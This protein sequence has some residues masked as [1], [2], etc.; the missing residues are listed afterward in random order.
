MKTDLWQLTARELTDGYRAGTFT[1]LEALT[2]IEGRLDAVNAKINAVVARD[3]GAARVQA[4]AATSRWR[5]GKPLSPIDGVP[6]TIKDNLLSAGLPAT[7][8][9][10]LYSGH[11]PAQDEAPVVRL[12]AAGAVFLGKTN[13]PEFTLQ[14]Y[15]TNLTFGTTENPHAPGMTPGGSTGGGAAAVA[16]GIGPVA[17]GTDGGGSLR[18]PAAHCGLYALK[19]SIGQIARYNGF[20]Q[21]L[22][23]FEVVGPVARNMEDLSAVFSVLKGY[24]TADPSSLWALAPPQPLP[25]RARIAYLPKIGSAPIDPLI[26]EAADAFAMQ[27][28]EAGHSIETIKTPYDVDSVSAAWSTIAASGLHWHLDSIGRR[29]GLGANALALDAQGGARTAAD[30]ADAMAV[31]LAARADAGRLLSRYDLLL[32]PSTAALAWPADT[33]YPAEIDGKPVGPRGHAVF[34]GWMNVTGVCA[35]NIPVAM[36][37]DHG[38]IG[39]QLVAAVGRDAELIDFVSNLPPVRALG[40]A[41]LSRRFD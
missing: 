34:T 18:R 40:P 8:G 5:S 2:S 6:L 16:A 11:M 3:R 21:I 27:L 36:T 7:W 4:E 39:M 37:A 31:A 24:D 20:P 15:T 29:E 14:G 33:A 12:R 28:G 35:V 9:S 38:G 41:R 26:A 13:V 19:P 10:K 32:C 30:Y 23:D 17:I 22:L 1:P 25:R